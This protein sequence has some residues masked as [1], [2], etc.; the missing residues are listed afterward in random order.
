MLGVAMVQKTLRE[1][2]R[3]GGDAQLYI[4]HDDDRIID[5]YFITTAPVRGFEKIV[6]GKNPLFVIEAVMRI[7]GICHAA[8]GIAAVEAFEDALGI[9]P[10]AN[11]RRL[12]EII[13][14]LNRVQ[15]H[16][17]HLTLLLPDILPNEILSKKLLELINLINRVN[18][19]MMRIGGAPTHPPYI[20]IGG[21]L[22]MPT[23]TVINDSKKKLADIIKQYID[24]REG[25]R[26]FIDKCSSVVKLKKQYISS[27][28]D[29]LATHLFYGDR[30][31]FDPSKITVK[32]YDE[33]RG[34][35]E[36]GSKSTSMIALY[37][38]RIVEASPRARLQLFREYSGKSLW[39]LQEARFIEIELVLHRILELLDRIRPNAPHRT[40]TLVY[41]HGEGIGV[42]EAPRG[43]LVHFV[44]L[45]DDGRV[46]KY[47]IIVPTMF[48]IPVL[49][50]SLID[51]EPSLGDLAARLFDPCVPCSTH[52]LR[53]RK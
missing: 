44:E 39:D 49:E 52:C 11:G 21:V 9:M 20:A 34:N 29:I 3:I 4:I 31:A 30:Y 35:K 37:D 22:K 5:A 23:E 8:H 15:S 2:D 51:L 10:P 41:E 19:V 14:L 28:A 36:I 18:D 25:L 12:R 26:E 43:T 47:K 27:D 13:G 7:C 45:N 32:R 40:G 6:L 42:Y 46:L 48:N 16:L 1:L 17:Y 33:Y 50:K 38:D 24:Y 53:V